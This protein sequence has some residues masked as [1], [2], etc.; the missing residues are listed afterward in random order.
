MKGTQRDEFS[1]E[2]L[3]NQLSGSWTKPRRV[4]TK[5]A[6]EKKSSTKYKVQKNSKPFPGNVGEN[7]A[8][9]SVTQVELIEIPTQRSLRTLPPAPHPCWLHRM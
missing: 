6:R 3:F 5:I 9:L 8:C 2:P 4:S 1:L 7:R